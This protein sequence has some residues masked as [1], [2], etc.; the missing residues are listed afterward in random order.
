[1]ITALVSKYTNDLFHVTAKWLDLYNIIN[2]YNSLIV[3]SQAIG[4]TFIGLGAVEK[5]CHGADGLSLTSWRRICPA[6]DSAS[7]TLRTTHSKSSLINSNFFQNLLNY[8]NCY[9]Q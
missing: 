3:I 7:K 1:M 8:I 4:E 9:N 6:A 2:Q 5:F